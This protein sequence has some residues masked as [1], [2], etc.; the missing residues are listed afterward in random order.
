MQVKKVDIIL[1][2]SINAIIGPVG[3]FK[4]ML[5]DRKY[6]ENRGYDISVYTSE[7][8]I[9]GA[10]R[11]APTIEHVQADAAETTSLVWRV[12]HAIGTFIRNK[13]RT[14][15]WFAIFM[16]ER[17]KRNVRKLIKYYVQHDQNTDVVQCHSD[18]EMYYY[19]KLRNNSHAITNM[20]LHTDGYPFKMLLMYH[21]C[22]EGTKY[23]KKY[24]ENFNWTV[25]NVDNI[26]FIAKVGQKNFLEHFSCRNKD[27]T[28]VI[29]NGIND[30]TAD[31][32]KVIEVYKSKTYDFKY[33]MCCTG[34]INNRKGHRFIVEAL[35]KLP[36]ELVN[37]I[38]VDFLGEGAERPILE[39]LVKKYGL[40]NNITFHGVVPNVDVYKYLAQNNIYILMSKNEGLPISIIE[41]MRAS[42]MV[43]STKISGIPELVREGYNGFLMNPDTDELVECLM[44]LPETDIEEMGKNSRFRFENEFTFARMEREFCDMYDNFYRKQ[45]Q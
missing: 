41:A 26:E 5:G 14:N 45:R 28:G 31:Q 34:T 8:I 40:T 15:K 9:H 10:Y 44:K 35:H 30:L 12:R 19:L 27:N 6:F 1:S 33:R 38:H 16:I 36:M 24:E 3:T 32:I 18:L 11:V 23:F 13:A 43:I 29:L 21:P 37:L 39:N 7:S 42:M 2:G 4:R 25:A 20:F 22:L 17:S